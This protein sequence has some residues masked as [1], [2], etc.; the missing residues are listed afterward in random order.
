M[1]LVAFYYFLAHLFIQLFVLQFMGCF[2]K[3]PKFFLS[4]CQQLTAVIHYHD[5]AAETVT[6]NH[7]YLTSLCKDLFGKQIHSIP[8][9]HFLNYISASYSWRNSLALCKSWTDLHRPDPCCVAAWP[10]PAPLPHFL[11]IHSL[12]ITTYQQPPNHNSNFFKSYL[13]F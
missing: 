8:N 12:N 9:L 6:S 2:A 5:F 11:L 10:F 3:R 1:C 13:F 4:S 7:S